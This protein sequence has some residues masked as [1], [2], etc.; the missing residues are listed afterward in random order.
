M[1]SAL[2]IE[3]GNTMSACWGQRVGSLWTGCRQAVGTLSVRCSQSVATSTE[4]LTETL[5]GTFTERDTQGRTKTRLRSEI[6][7]VL[8][9]PSDVRPQQPD[10]EDKK[11]GL[12]IHGPSQITEEKA[13]Q[14]QPV[15]PTQG[16]TT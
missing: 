7:S 1:M 2:S 16:L 15:S 13:A 4:T 6:G 12:R 11:H 10:K 3:T 14:Y 9:L 5:T 8:P